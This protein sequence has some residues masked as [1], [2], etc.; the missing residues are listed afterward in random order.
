MSAK[1]RWIAFTSFSQRPLVAALAVAAV[2]PLSSLRTLAAQC[3]PDRIAGDCDAVKARDLNRGNPVSNKIVV[4]EIK[5]KARAL[6]IARGGGADDPATRAILQRLDSLNFREANENDPGCEGRPNRAIAPGVRAFQAHPH[7]HRHHTHPATSLNLTHRCSEHEETPNAFYDDSTHSVVA[8]PV[9]MRLAPG[10][11]ASIFAHELGHVVSPCTLA[12]E[13]Y[14]KTADFSADEAAGRAVDR[15]LGRR[16]PVARKELAFRLLRETG[17][18]TMLF[19][20]NLLERDVAQ[21]VR[22]LKSCGLIRKTA[23]AQAQIAPVFDEVQ[24]C[25]QHKN[26]DAFRKMV[27]QESRAPKRLRPPRDGEDLPDPH[28]QGMADPK[29]YPAQCFGATEEE[30]ADAFGSEVFGAWLGDQENAR[31]RSSEALTQMRKLQCL[32][33][34][35]PRSTGGDAEWRYPNFN[36]RLFAIMNSEGFRKAQSCQID[37]NTRC[38]W[39]DP[40]AG[41]QTNEAATESGAA[42][43]EQGRE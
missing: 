31:T 23:D 29:R 16:A 1:S 10:A 12:K 9:S 7:G 2:L 42:S 28:V 41:P 14:A 37:A 15:C 20:E 39:R 13:T 6:I 32:S 43:A 8:C 18:T 5:E 3:S 22:K 17:A 35:G 40:A 26:E 4:A 27:A 21:V 11:W 19:P 36:T 24:R 33:E 30:F 25:L 38:Y 34:A